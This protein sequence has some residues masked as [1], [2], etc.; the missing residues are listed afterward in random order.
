MC[1]CKYIDIGLYKGMCGE[2]LDLHID[3]GDLSV[4]RYIKGVHEHIDLKGIGGHLHQRLHIKDMY[5]HRA[6]GCM[7]KGGI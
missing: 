5:M 3:T 4:C 6:K 7:C 2:D 1:P